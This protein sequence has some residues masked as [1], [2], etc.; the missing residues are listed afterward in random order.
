VCAVW[1]FM[2]RAESRAAHLGQRALFVAARRLRLPEAL[3]HHRCVTGRGAVPRK[4]R[5][6]AGR[7]RRPRRA[8]AGGADENRQ[9]TTPEKLVRPEVLA[10]S[11]YHVAERAG[12]VKLDAMENPY[13]LP[14][15]LLRE[16]GK[17]LSRVAL[18]ST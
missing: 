4:T 9:V 14:D 5:G 15:A 7:R 6:Y 13:S 10:M 17:A 1:R 16:L 12:L 11:A 3:E 2:R 8:C 18:N